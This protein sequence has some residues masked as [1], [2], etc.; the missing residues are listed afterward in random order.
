[1]GVSWF[2]GVGLVATPANPRCDG[3]MGRGAASVMTSSTSAGAP[4]GCLFCWGE[5]LASYPLPLG[6]FLLPE[7]R[8]ALPSRR[9]SI[10]PKVP[11]VRQAFSGPDSLPVSR[12]W[13]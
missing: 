2:G 1:M 3:T 8:P 7:V 6:S 13:K 12:S 5:G 4:Q 9:S 10:A 11:S